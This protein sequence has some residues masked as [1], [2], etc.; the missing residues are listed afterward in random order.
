MFAQFSD[1]EKAYENFHAILAK[2]TPD[3]LWD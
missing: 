1:G 2:S 3:N